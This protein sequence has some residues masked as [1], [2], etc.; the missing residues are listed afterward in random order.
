VIASSHSA[1]RSMVSREDAAEQ[2]SQGLRHA[3][4]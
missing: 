3:H 2:A 4:G 1:K